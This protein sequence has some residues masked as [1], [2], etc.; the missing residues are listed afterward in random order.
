MCRPFLYVTTSLSD[1]ICLSYAV[2]PLAGIRDDVFIL[3]RRSTDRLLAPAR[4]FYSVIQI[5]L[6]RELEA[7]D[8]DDRTYSI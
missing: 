6:D 2:L 5:E 1:R 3:D 4:A 8:W 7:P